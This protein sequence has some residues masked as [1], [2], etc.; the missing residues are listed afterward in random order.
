MAYRKIE[1]KISTYRLA[2]ITLGSGYVGETY[3]GGASPIELG[4]ILRLARLY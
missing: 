1:K 3:L 4:D 2:Q